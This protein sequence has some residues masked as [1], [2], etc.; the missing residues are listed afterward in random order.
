MKQTGNYFVQPRSF[1]VKHWA[2]QLIFDFS[3]SDTVR[4]KLFYGQSNI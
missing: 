2:I 4:N 3:A 1:G